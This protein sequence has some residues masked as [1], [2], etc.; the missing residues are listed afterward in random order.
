M[1]LLEEGRCLSH[2]RTYGPVNNSLVVQLNIFSDYY[3]LILRHIS[4][5]I[6]AAIKY[7]P[8]PNNS[9]IVWIEKQREG[10]QRVIIHIIVTDIPRMLVAC[11]Q[12]S[13]HLHRYKLR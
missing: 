4:C 12:G 1:R 3:A 13:I 8:N 6:F 2:C 7:P 10:C 11:S 5:K 9:C